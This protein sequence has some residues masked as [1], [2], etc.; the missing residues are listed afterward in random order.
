[1]WRGRALDDKAAFAVLFER[2][3]PVAAALIA[4]ILDHSQDVDDVLQEAAVQ[5]LVCLGRLQEAA[6]FGPWLCGI[7]SNLARRQ[8]RESARRPK[9][10][11]RQ[12]GRPSTEE[13]LEEAE[14][15]AKVRHAVGTL[16]PGQREA[17]QLF[18]L[19]GLNEGEV[20]TELG[21]AR[22]AVKSRLHKARRSLSGHLPE[23]KGGPRC[24]DCRWWT[25]MWSM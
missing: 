12:A 21:I 15:V 25:S 17:V 24:P 11:P 20:A 6:R 9:L 22:T 1:M 3:R 23:E 5:A 16:P 14:T 7:A 13:L 2:H 10:A 19:D 8:L 4:R 18:Y